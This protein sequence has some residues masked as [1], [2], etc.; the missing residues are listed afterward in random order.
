MARLIG[1][2]ILLGYAVL[3]RGGVYRFDWS[4][5]L[6][7]LGLLVM[8]IGVGSEK[9]G[10]RSLLFVLLPAYVAMQVPLSLV[11]AATVEHLLRVCGYVAAFLLVRELK[12][13]G[14]W[15]AVPL[16]V[17][18]GLE[19]VLGLMQFYGDQTPVNAHGTY[20]NRNHFA[21]LLEMALPFA[22]MYPVTVLK[23]A[24]HRYS[25]PALPAL[26]ACVGW[27][28]AALILV[29]IIHSMSRMGFVACLGA[30]GVMGILM[31]PRHKRPRVSAKYA[32]TCATVAVVIVMFIFLPPDQLV[33]R[34]AGLASTEEVS[35]EARH[36]IW[37]ETLEMVKAHPW[38]G[39][40]MG[41]YESAFL[42]YKAVA[43]MSTVDFAHNDYL[44]LLA[45]LG[46]VGFGLVAVLLGILIRRTARLMRDLDDP[47]RQ[48]IGIAAAGALTAILL[49]S[50]ADFNLYIPANGV[51]LA[52]I[53]GITAGARN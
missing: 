13:Q 4:L 42:K 17:I 15:A 12:D 33:E 41:A 27:S 25:A 26:K 19:A 16:V 9:R 34:F 46:I 53:G 14:W 32:W 31:V 30:L 11:P 3:E 28:V 44:Q 47:D 20:V 40:G 38:L 29:G 24:H 50:T 10:A 23:K 22:V 8:F 21:G 39:V 45:E 18:A 1:L 49:H 48:C 5:C 36:R 35:S 37:A 2:S 7:G 43:P 52:W 6:L 51:V